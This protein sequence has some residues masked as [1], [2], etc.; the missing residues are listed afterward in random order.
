MS[1]KSRR[2][3]LL[4]SSISINSIKDSVTKFTKGLSKSRDIA[5]NIIEQ[6]RESNTFKQT[7]IGKDNEFF[8]KRNNSNF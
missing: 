7:L 3:S 5:S 4:K 6:T 1:I 2:N 8:R